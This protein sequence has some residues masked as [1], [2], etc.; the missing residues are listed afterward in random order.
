MEAPA[1]TPIKPGSA[2]GFLNKPCKQEPDIA[3]LA[4]TNPAKSLP[5]SR[6]NSG[7]DQ[8]WAIAFAVKDY[9]VPW[10]PINKTPLGR[11]SPKFLAS[12]E[13]A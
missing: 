8:L 12:S 7:I 13:K 5:T 10:G 2:S 4:P 6:R 1:D 9:P 3:K 11:G